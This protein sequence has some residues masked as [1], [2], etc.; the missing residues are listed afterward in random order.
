MT[1]SIIIFAYRKPGTTPE[2]F[3]KHYEESH[4][5]LLREIAGETFP[6][7]HTRRYILRAEGE[8]EGTTRNATTPASVLMGSQADF[9]FDAT[10]ELIF[11][12][13]AEFQKFFKALQGTPANAAKLGANEELFLDL[14]KTSI[15]IVGE[16]LVTTKE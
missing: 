14:T 5:P 4:I 12:D 7:S 13:A 9:D 16:T 10:A 11:K 8:A 15:A 3:K 2:Q 6:L 1:Y